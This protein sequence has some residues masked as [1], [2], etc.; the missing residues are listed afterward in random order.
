M[1]AILG[2]IALIVLFI[3]LSAFFSFSNEGRYYDDHIPPM[4]YPISYERVF[5]ND[6]DSYHRYHY[7]RRRE[8][9]QRIIATSVFAVVIV[10][11][12][13]LFAVISPK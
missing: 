12:F 3:V 4:N 10:V 8:Q 7:W 13:L 11:L 2:I 6:L 9:I 1:L 5:H